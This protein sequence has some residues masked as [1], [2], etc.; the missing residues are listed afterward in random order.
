MNFI[1]GLGNPGDQYKL[2]KHNFGFWV[3]DKLIE[4]RSLTVKA[5]KGDYIFAKDNKNIFIKPTGF[6][7][8]SGI[9]IAQILNYYSVSVVDDII[10]IYEY[11]S[12]CF[13]LCY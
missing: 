12:F 10:I 9:A 5:G 6:M 1:I 3:L 2:T 7:N 11:S 13:D 8:N 4:N